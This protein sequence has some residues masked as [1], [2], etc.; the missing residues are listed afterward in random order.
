MNLLEKILLATDLSKSSKN[1]VE[2]AIGLAK[3]FRS[4]IILIHVLPDDIKNE[5][6]RLLL[7]EAAIKRLGAIND[8]IISKG[9]K[10][11]KPILEYGNYFDKIIQTAD[12]INANMILIGAGEKLKNDIFQ[13]GTTAEKII[14]KSVIPVWIIKNDNPLKIENILCPVDFSSESKRALK[15]AIIIARRFKAELVILSVYKVAY[16]GSLRLQ[17]AWD[18]QNEYVRSEH[19]KEFNL[20]LD[21]FNMTDLSWDKEIRG[22]DPATEILQAISRDEFG[23]LIMGTTGKTGLGR[24]MMGSVTEKVTREV[25]CSFITLKT[26]DI[27]ELQLKTEIRDIESHYGVAMELIKDGFLNEAINEFK[28]CLNINHMH[29]PSLN[30][31]AKVYDKLSNAVDAEKYKNMAKE[32]LATIWDRKIEA[33]ARKFYKF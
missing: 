16:S 29:I 12:S 27:I 28:I 17:I 22:G 3:I 6:A 5:K 20:F 10:T 14:R 24:I 7:D 25:P 19:K 13:L 15:N 9:I 21:K 32:V 23:L 31:I 2:N 8:R 33:E 11:A 18:E 26:K 4:K 1:V 30:G